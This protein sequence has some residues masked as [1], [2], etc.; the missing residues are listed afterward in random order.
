[1]NSDIPCGLSLLV[2][3]V[4]KCCKVSPQ[5]EKKVGATARGWGWGGLEARGRCGFEFQGLWE[6]RRS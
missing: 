5:R 4:R 2:I 3:K 6:V 1:M